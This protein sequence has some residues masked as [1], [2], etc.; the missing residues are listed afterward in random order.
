M[1][2]FVNCVHI[3]FWG[4]QISD[5]IVWNDQGKLSLDMIRLKAHSWFNGPG[6]LFNALG[7]QMEQKRLWWDRKGDSS[8]HSTVILICRDL[9]FS[10][11]V[12]HVFASQTSRCIHPYAVFSTSSKSSVCL[13]GSTRSKSVKFC[14]TSQRSNG[15]GPLC[16]SMLD[17]VHCERY[18]YI[19][20]VEL[21][22]VT[23]CSTWCC[24]CSSFIPFPI[25]IRFGNAFI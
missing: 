9:Q 14:H 21:S 19:L 5:E 11:N 10:T 18:I 6:A 13:A 20:V 17:S 8:R 7:I 25:S 2:K 1:S 4:S 3:Y 23:P 16:W 22:R 12:K 24:D 15:S